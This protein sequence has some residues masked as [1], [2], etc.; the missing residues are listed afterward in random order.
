MTEAV[1]EGGMARHAGGHGVR[2]SRHGGWRLTTLLVAV[3]ATLPLA[4][5]VARSQGSGD[6]T[7]GAS[8]DSALRAISRGV[9]VLPETVTVGDPFRV[10]VRV[11]APRGATLE[12]AAV[13][14]SGTGVEALDPVHVVP[15]LDSTATEQTATYRLA[16]W[17]VGARAIRIPD[18][19]VRDSLGVRRVAVGRT[20]SVFVATVLPAD[21]TER[22]PRPPRALYEFGPPWWWWALVALVALGVLVAVWWLWRRRR[23]PVSA[24]RRSPRDEAEAAFGRVEALELVASGERGLHVALMAEVLRDYLSRVVPSAAPSLTSSEL[25]LQ[26][27]GDGRL[28]LPRL[29]RLL[30]DVDLVKFAALPIDAVRAEALGGEARALVEAI[31]VA[32]QPREPAV[33]PGGPAPRDA[34]EAA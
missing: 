11:R 25:L 22:V 19:I 31:D 18:V 16:A 23:Q 33:V 32:V 21:S 6:R 1:P 13:P 26:L 29:V 30:Q 24:V 5:R 14:D 20:L 28:P 9:A 8:A 17:D 2:R 27:R 7:R 34:R 15:T 3:I 4:P 10:V 12:F